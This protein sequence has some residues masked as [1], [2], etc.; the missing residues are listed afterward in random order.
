MKNK[1]EESRKIIPK[2]I[3]YMKYMKLVLIY[4]LFTFLSDWSKYFI[5]IRIY[6]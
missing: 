3:K 6:I 1:F 5:H 2:Y 4:Y